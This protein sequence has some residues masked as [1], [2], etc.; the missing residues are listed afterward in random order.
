MDVSPFDLSQLQKYYV[1]T[2]IQNPN[3]SRQ[4]INKHYQA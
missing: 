3:F 2:A 4:L 1:L